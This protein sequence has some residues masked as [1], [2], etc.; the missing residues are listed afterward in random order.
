MQIQPFF[1]SKGVFYY[2]IMHVACA[3]FFLPGTLFAQ[4]NGTSN[5]LPEINLL[6]AQT[7]AGS[8]SPETSSNPAKNSTDS[9]V[10]GEEVTTEKMFGRKGGYIHPYFNLQEEWTNNLYNINIDEIDNFRTAASA[11][12]WFGFPRVDEAPINFS[13][14]NSALGGTRLSLREDD[15]FNRTLLYLFGVVDYNMYSANSNLN[16]LSWRL[17]GLYQQNLPAGIS[18]NIIDRLTR[19]Q[20]AFDVGSFLPQDFTRE[21][22]NIYV[23]STPSLIR[24]YYSNLANLSIVFNTPSKFSGELQLSNFLLNYDNEENN[25]LNRSDTRYS[26]S[27]KFNYSQKT[28]FFITY[29]H[30]IITYDTATRS[31]G[32]SSFYTAGT[33]WKGSDKGSLLL[34]G[35]YQTKKYDTGIAEE[36]TTFTTQMRL[37]YSIT[38]KTKIHFDLYKALEETNSTIQ[39][40][41]DT[42]A[43]NFH[44]E[45]RFSYKFLGKI[46][47]SYETNDYER[48]TN[49]IINDSIENRK[50]Y[51]FMV[52]P[53][54][55]YTIRDW[56]RIDLAYIFDNRNSSE[57]IYDFTTQTITISLE[58]T[59]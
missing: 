13:T 51:S 44:Y 56:M 40:G 29:D 55:E 42:I 31:D 9:Y 32:N 20:D 48:L 18:L 49:T 11:G 8:T 23:S 7:E 33:T 19:D 4:G 57:N 28:N 38:D 22:G 35:G 43:A 58:I 47:F 24:K 30:V 10:V 1:F 2:L 6:P 12:V 53:A 25:W 41:M 16:H 17:E 34:Q 45:Q 54:L 15:S 27:V 3:F 36:L 39:S 5:I 46:D 37:N 14:H 52:R 50:D 59:F 26:A 21:E